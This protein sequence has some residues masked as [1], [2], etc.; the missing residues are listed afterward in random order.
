MANS[1]HILTPTEVCIIGGGPSGLMAAEVLAQAGHKVHVFDA[2]PS[3]GRKF[4]LAGIGGLNITHSEDKRVF[5]QRYTSQENW[6]SGWLAQFD[7]EAVCDW[8]HGL[9]VETFIGSSGRVFP[10]E[11]KAAPLLRAWLQRLRGLGVKIHPRSRWLGWNAQGALRIETAAGEQSVRATAVLLA[12]GGG[13]WPRLGSDAA[14]IPLLQQQGVAV[15]PLEA[16][17]C[18]FD[19]AVWSTLLLDKWL[20]APVKNCA[21]R[22][23]GG[24]YRQGEWMLTATGVEGSLV[25]A[26]SAHIRQHLAARG[27]CLIE[28]D[29][30]PHK[31]L[32]EVQCALEKPRGKRTLTKHLQVQLGLEGVKAA[33]LRECAPAESFNDMQ[34][35][36]SYIKALPIELLRARPMAEA[37]S[38]AGGV[39]AD[40]LDRNLMLKPLPGVFCTGEMLDWDAPTGGYL[41]TACL[42][43]GFVAGHGMLRWLAGSESGVE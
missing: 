30:L 12:L 29:C 14:W 1:Q 31:S 27:L 22:V 40:M 13:S 25:Y 4:L 39:Q 38:T 35:L 34:Q 33:L 20:A 7:A 2:M 18:G 19:V 23:A 5:L 42:A 10:K 11:M 28:M 41:L 24:S 8:V 6:V 43:S 36:A 17:N 15:R 9:G 21:L 26:L 32:A 37:I 3:L 16:S